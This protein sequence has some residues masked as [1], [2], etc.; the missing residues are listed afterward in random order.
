MI[1]IGKVNEL[2]VVSQQGINTYLGTGASNNILLVDKKHHHQIGDKLSAFV[3]V[4]SD[5]HLAATSTIPLVQADEVAYLKLL[6]VNYYGAFFDWGLPKDLLVPFSEQHQEL[7]VGKYYLVKVFLDEQQRLVASTKLHKHLQEIDEDQQFKVGQRVQLI[8][9]EHTDLGIRAIVNHTHWGMLYRN[10]VFQELNR[11][12]KLTGYIK[13]IRA[14]L[15]LDLSLQAAGYNN[16]IKPLTEQ[17]LE[18]LQANN[19]RLPLGDKTSPE[20]IYASFAVSKKAYKQAIGALYKQRL[21]IIEDEQIR[22]V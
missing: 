22:S 18:K 3:Y 9:A 6:A 16:N 11:G 7:E 5:G 14:D 4:D 20:Q 21:I 19:G 8:I 17:I 10:E 12:Q 15:K 2:K 1:H 13:Q